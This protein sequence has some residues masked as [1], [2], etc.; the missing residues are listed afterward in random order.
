MACDARLPRSR[1]PVLRAAWT[2]DRRA[3]RSTSSP[4]IAQYPGSI[5]QCL[6]AARENARAV[7]GTITSDV[8]ETL[9]TTYLESGGSTAAMPESATG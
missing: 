7:R 2:T 8:W 5:V 9:N 3:R 6:R 4:S 1:R